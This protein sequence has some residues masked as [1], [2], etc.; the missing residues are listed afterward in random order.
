MK[1]AALKVSAPVVLPGGRSSFVLVLLGLGFFVLIGRGIYLQ[2]IN[3]GFL[4]SQGNSRFSRVVEIPAHRGK[5]TD[6][7]GEPLAISTPVKSLWA[8][9]GQ[10][11][12]SPEQWQELAVLLE[13]NVG[14]LRKRV[15]EAG[16]FLYLKRA[17]PPEVAQRAMSLGIK[18]LYEQREYR[19]FYPAGEVAAH[20]VGITDIDDNG[21]EGLELAHQAW[22]G[23][24]PG[25]RRVII[26]R[27]G[28]AVEDL[29]G[30][31]LPQEGRELALSIDLK[32][33]YL[34]YRELHAAVQ[35]HKAKAGGVVVLDAVSGEILALANLPSYNPNNRAK[36]ARD[37]ARN[38]ALTDTFEPGSTLKPFTIAAALE[39]GKLRPETVVGTL[40]GRLQIGPATIHDAHPYESL[41][42]E[43]V[44]Q[45]SSNIGSARIALSLPAET[46]WRTLAQA[47]FG[48]TP[49][50]GFPGEVAGRLR[51]AKSWRPIEQATIAYGHGIS[52]NL[53]QL[54]RAYTVFAS[55]GELKP[56]SLLKTAGPVA[57][58]P[59]LRRETVLA[60]RKMLEMA[61]QPG[62]TAPK[63]QV[64]GYRVAGKTGTAH[65]VEGAGYAPDKFVS[66]FVGFAPV[67]R[68]RLIVAVMIDEPSAGQHYGGSVA[69]PVFSKITEAALR[70]MNLPGDGPAPNRL[71]PA[72]ETEDVREET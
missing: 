70:A 18:G 52:V 32:L 4:Q 60:V 37:K 36:L 6:R 16:D 41:T 31:R 38:R 23:G 40:G 7:Q 46:M 54:A 65:K 45:K 49:Q 44:I 28:D 48:N 61:V 55:D 17:L 2:A 30:V 9:A 63:A 24:K 5:I 26:N 69:A 59:M 43:Q 19:R 68:P 10:L 67:S 8:F 22:L 13:T 53:V 71:V 57:G 21:Q 64:A 72:T 33:Q 15:A 66:S 42:V 3:T 58:Q 27:R 39:A 34:A 62:G 29:E 11:E 56:V 47:G 35:A 20:L 1:S 14:M 50:T 51:P 12:A 25:S